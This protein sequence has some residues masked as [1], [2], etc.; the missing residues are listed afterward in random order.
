M[1][2][3]S[4]SDINHDRVFGLKAVVLSPSS[5]NFGGSTQGSA[6]VIDAIIVDDDGMFNSTT[7]TLPFLSLMH[8]I[9]NSSTRSC[10]H[11]YNG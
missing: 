2:I 11:S 10:L 4:N 7:P 3:T 6:G 1:P 5:A 9:S 8:F